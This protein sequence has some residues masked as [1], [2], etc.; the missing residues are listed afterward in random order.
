MPLIGADRDAVAAPRA[1]D[2]HAAHA[3]VAH[4]GEG[5]LLRAVGQAVIKTRI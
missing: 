3:H 5:D 4:F 2:Q 1:I